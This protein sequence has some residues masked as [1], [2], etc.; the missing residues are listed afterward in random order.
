[1]SGYRTVAGTLAE[2]FAQS[3]A[4]MSRHG[5]VRFADWKAPEAAEI[6]RRIGQEPCTPSECLM[7][8]AAAGLI[9]SCQPPDHLTGDA[10]RI[11]HLLQHLEFKGYRVRRA[12]AADVPSLVELERQ[13]WDEALRAPD[14]AL[15]RRLARHPDGQLVLIVDGTVAA[16]IYSQRIA[17]TDELTGETAVTVEQLHEAAATTVQ[18]LAVNVLPAMQH[19]SLGDALLELMLIRCS[20]DK[21]VKAVAAVTL[22]RS[23]DRTR[24]QP[25]EDYIR[26]RNASGMLS[27][28]ILRFHE[29]HGAKVD[30]L[31]PGYRPHDTRNDGHG[32]LVAYDIRCR[33]RRELH[34]EAAPTGGD[35]QRPSP[36]EIQ[37]GVRSAIAACLGEER[38]A[39]FSP[40]RPLME[41]GLN[42]A[43]LLELGETL[44][45]RHRVPIAPAFFFRHN[46]A[47]KIVAHITQAT[48][49]GQTSAAEPP[50]PGAEER[51]AGRDVAI[52]GMACRLPGGIATPDALWKCL[53]DGKSV[54]SELPAGRWR[55][56]DGIDPSGSH[57]GIARGG[58]LD[59]VADFDAPFFRLSP[60]EAETMDPQQ[61]ILLELCWQAV[62]HAGHA[63]KTLA[64]T[65]TGVFVG[66]SGSDYARLLD[67]SGLP[68][69]AH[70]GTG[71][72]MAVLANR[73]SYFFDLLGPSL[74]LDTACSSSL[75]AVHEAV[76][77]I[78][79]GESAQALVAGVSLILHP[80][81]SVAYYKSGMLSKDGRCKTFDRSA[82]GYVRSEGAVA[83]LLK[84]LER[85]RADGDRIYAVI[86]GTA[87]NHGGQASGLTVPNPDQQSR[88]LEAAWKEAGIDPSHL[89]YIEAH[90]TGTSLGDPI[91]VEGIR[92]AFEHRATTWSGR[93]GLG[94]VKT[95]LGHLE[96]TAGLAGLM[97]AVLCLEH[98]QIPASV[99]FCELNPRIDVAGTGLY[100]VDRLEPWSAPEGGGPRLAGVSSFGSGG[101]NAHV[102]VAE[103]PNAATT[104]PVGDHNEPILFLLSARTQQQLQIYARAYA[105]WLRT[106][107][108]RAVPLSALARLL[109]IGRQAMEARLAL[110]V[111]DREDLVGRLATVTGTSTGDDRASTS[112]EPE[113]ALVRKLIADG[114]LEE[115]AALWQRGAQIDWSLLYGEDAGFERFS[116]PTYPFARRTYWIPNAPA[117]TI[118]KSSGS[119]P[120]EHDISPT[121]LAPVWLPVGNIAEAPLVSAGNGLI[122]GGDSAQREAL[123]SARA[124]THTMANDPGAS[125]NV[126]RDKLAPLGPLDHVIWI[127]PRRDAPPGDLGALAAAQ[128][129]G[130]LAAFRLVKAMIALGHGK[131]PLEWTVV[132]E[133]AQAV[134]ESDSSDPAHAGVHA[135]FNALVKEL[136]R[137]SLRAVDL[138]NCGSLPGH[139]PS[140]HDGEVLARRSGQWL[141]RT[142]S[143]IR[144]VPDA[145]PAY[146]QKGVYVVI[147]GAG[148]I[149]EA[150]SRHVISNYQ[151]Q[152]IWIGRSQLCSALEAKLDA[153]A[154]L[155]P[156][157]IYIAADASSLDALRAAHRKIK[158]LFPAIHGVL[159]A[160]V[161]AFD[162]S[163]AE[164]DE[165][166]FREVLSP[167][168]DASLRMAEVFAA[169]PLDFMIFFSSVVA[170]ERSGG[171]AGYAAGGAFEDA[172][173]VHLDR[174]MSF[175][176][177]V[178]NW[179]HWEVGTGSAIADAARTRL[180]QSGGAPI[181]PDEAMPALDTLIS[182]P[183]AQMALVKTARAGE[184]PFVDM[185]L[186]L[187]FQPDVAPSQ[188]AQVRGQ[189]AR[190]V[191]RLRPASLFN[192]APLEAALTPLLSALLSALGPKAGANA[193]A[194]YERWLDASRRMLSGR[195]ARPSHPT[196]IAQAWQTWSEAKR[197]LLA[198]ADLTAAVD[199]AEACLQAL[200]DVLVGLTRAT[201]VIFPGAS[202]RRV[203]G[204]YRSNAVAEDF[205]RSLTDALVDVVQA[206]LRADPAAQLRILEVGAGT[207][208]TTTTVL[209]RLAP[210]TTN[211][212]EYAYTD[213]SKAFLFH[214]EQ[215]FVAA[216]PFVT[217]RLFDVERPL[218]GQAIAPGTYDAVIATNVLHATR[219]IRRTL[220]NCKAALRK[221]GL[222]LLNEISTPSLFAHVTFGLLEGWWL[223]EDQALRL[224]DAPGLSPEA[225][226]MV[227]EQGGFPAV[228][229]PAPH[230]HVLGQQ[231]IVAESD[232]V[233]WQRS[234]PSA[235]SASTSPQPTLAAAA[236]IQIAGSDG[237]LKVAADA[238]LRKLVARTLR[239]DARELDVH[240]P[241]KTYGIDS[242]LIVQITEALRASF[243]DVS[244]TLLFECQTIDALSQHFLARNR[245]ELEGLTGVKARA[246]KPAST[247]R[248]TILAPSV[249]RSSQSSAESP[250]AIA[251]IGMSGRF[252]GAD[253]LDD[254]WRILKDGQS[255][256]REVPP[257][258]WPLEGFFLADADQAVAQGKSYSKWGGFLDGVTEFDPLFF[259]ISPKEAVAIDPQERLF[260]E[261]AWEALEDAGYTPERISRDFSRALGVFVG[262]TRTG[263]DLFGPE[264]WSRGETVYPHTSFSSAANRLSYFLNAKGP[265]VPVDTMCSSSLTAIHQACQSLRAGECELAIAGG[266][267]VYLHASGYVGLSA[268]R[269]LSPDG[270]CRSFGKGGNG[271]VPGEGVAAILLKPLD[272]AIEDRDRIC[273]VIRATHVNHG[274]RTNGYTVPNPKAQADLVRDALLKAGIDARR[275]SYIEAHGT[276]TEL[277]DPIEVAGLTEAF[278]HFTA[279]TQFCALG[280]AKSTIG[281]LEAAAGI[282]GFIKVVLQMRH[283][284]IAPSLHAAETNPNID[285]ARTPF[286]VQQSLGAWP[287]GEQPRLAGVSSF[288]AGGANAHVVIEEYRDP[289][290]VSSV[291]ADNASYP[292]VLSARSEERLRAYAAR[293][294]DFVRRGLSDGAPL[295]L[296]DVAFTLQV[297]RAQMDQRLG[298]I[299]S[300]LDEL[301]RKLGDYLDGVH[302]DLHVGHAKHHKPVISAID[303]DATFEQMLAAWFARGEHARLLG[304][305]T[306][307]LAIDWERLHQ[308]EPASRMPRRIALPTYPFAKTKYW[309]PLTTGTLSEPARLDVAG[310]SAPIATPEVAAPA[311]V[312]VPTIPSKPTAIRL[313]D[314]AS[315]PTTFAVGSIQPRTLPA[316]ETRTEVQKQA[317]G[318]A[319]L[320]VRDMGDGVLAVDAEG[321]IRPLPTDASCNALIRCLA[322]IDSQAQGRS[323][324][325]S[326]IKVL[327]L[328]GLDRL[329]IEAG[330]SG[331]PLIEK[332]A[333]ALASC[334]V[335]VVAV[336]RGKNSRQVIQLASAC[337]MMILSTECSAQRQNGYRG[338]IVPDS[339]IEA[340]ALA[341]AQSIARGSFV[342]LTT[343]KKH[344]LRRGD[345]QTNRPAPLLATEF[346]RPRS[347]T[348]GTPE[349]VALSSRVV[350][351]DRY[352]NSVALVT[353]ANRAG[354]NTFS[355]E[356][357]SGVLEAFDH[358]NGNPDYKAV[359]VTGYDGYFAC[360]GTREGLLA[361]QSGKARFTDE[362]SYVAPLRCDVPVIAAM[363]GHGIGAGWAMGL[364][365]DGAILA[366]EGVYQSPYMLYGFTP[367]AGS[368]LIFPERLGLDLARE[369]LFTARE[370]QGR[371]LKERGIALPVAPRAEVLPRALAL[372]ESL[373]AA[374]RQELVRRKTERVSAIR[375]CLPE[376]FAAELA[377]H[378]KTFVGNPEVV[379]GLARHFN[380]AASE[381]SSPAATGSAAKAEEP[382]SG[383]LLEALRQSLAHE[384]NMRR[385][386]VDDHAT[387]ID[388]GMD[389]I[390]AVTWIRKINK[391]HGLAIGATKV[392]S[393]PTLAEFHQHVL[394]LKRAQAAPEAASPEQARPEPARQESREATPAPLAKADAKP[395]EP[396]LLECFTIAAQGSP[397]LDIAPPPPV[398]AKE[399]EAK[400]ANVTAT[401]VRHR[402]SATQPIAI[403]GM[404]GQFPKA[405]SV[406]EF[407][408]NLVAGRDCISVVPP[409]RWSVDAYYDPDQNVPGKTVCRYMGVLEDIDVFD[410]L[411]FNI[412][413]SE[414][415]HMD[416]QQRLFLESSWRCIEDAGYDPA[417]L[418]AATCGVFVGCQ[419]N[420]YGRRTADRPSAH[421]LIGESVAMLPARI[422]YFLNLRGPCLTIDTACSASL[423]AIASACDS[424]VLGNADLALAGGVYISDGPDIHLKMSSAG[425][426]SPNGRC[427]TFDQR[428]NGFVLGEG[429]GVLLLK[430]LDDALR[431]GDP[432][433]AV[434]RGWGVNQDGKTNGITA[435][436]QESQASLEAGVY[437]R[438]GIDPEHIGLVEAHGTGTKLGDPIEVEA[439]CQSFRR[440]TD[441]T[442]FCAL[443]S[444]KSNIGHLA[445]A[446]GVTGVI[447]AALALE[448]RQ[449]PQT[450]NYERLNEHIALA[451][452]PFY[453][454]TATQAW[455]AEPGRQRLA[456]V[457]SFGFSGTNAHMVLEEFVQSEARPNENPAPVLVP[458]SAKSNAQ[459]ARY[460][461]T[462]AAHLAG[463][464]DRELADIA[465]TFQIGRTAMSHRLAVV[466]STVDELR[467]R[468]RAYASNGATGPQSFAGEVSK[469]PARAADLSGEDLPDLAKRWV[470]GET[471]DWDALYRSRKP[472]RLHGLPTY[473]FAREHYWIATD[474]EMSASTELP[475]LDAAVWPSRELPVEIDWQDR[476]RDWLGKRSLVVHAGEDERRS[477][478]H[479]LSRLQRSCGLESIGSV[480]YGRVGDAPLAKA[481]P[482]CLVLLGLSKAEITRHLAEARS[483]QTI[484]ASLSADPAE[485]ESIGARIAAS[486]A[487]DE[488]KV[489]LVSH[490]GAA[491]QHGVMQHLFREWLA[492]AG[493]S[494][495]AARRE[496]Y[497]TGTARQER[498]ARVASSPD[499]IAILAKEWHATAPEL[500][501]RPADRK[502]ALVLVNSETAEIARDLFEPADF[503]R[504]ILVGTD[505]AG[506]AVDFG[507]AHAARAAADALIARYPGITH[508]IDFASLHEAPADGDADP[509]GKVAFY[510]ALIGTSEDLA[511][512]YVTKGL[513]AFRSETMSLAGAKF[514]GL[515]RM[516]S[517]DYRHIEARHL[518]IDQAAFGSPAKLRRI[519]LDEL[520]T[521]LHETEICYRDGHR[522]VP[523]LSIAEADDQAESFEIAPDATYVVS[524]GTNGIGLEI[525]RHLADKGCTK[526][527]LMGIT[528]LPP[529]DTWSQAL[530]RDDVSPYIRAKLAALI[531]LDNV[532]EHLEIYTGPL[533]DLPALRRY[534]MKVRATLGPIRGV[535]HSAAVYSDATT[536]AFADKK[537][538][539]MQKVWEPKV[540]GLESLEAVFRADTL[541]FFVAFSSMT[542]LVPHLARGAG[543][544]AMANVFV[545]LFTAYHNRQHG[546]HPYK[547]IVW[548]DWNETG[549]ITRIG[550]DKAASIRETFE[551]LGLRTFSNAEGRRLFDAAMA[552][553][554]S[555]T[556]IGYLDRGRFAKVAPSLLFAT[557]EQSRRTAAPPSAP[558]LKVVAG[559][560]LLDHLDRWEA[561]KRA[562][563][564]ISVQSVTE[565]IGLD[566]IKSL[567]PSL[568]RRIHALLFGAVA[569][570]APSTA[571]RDYTHAITTTVMGVLKLKTVSPEQPLQNYGLDSISATVLATRL[572][573]MLEIEIRPQWLIEFPTIEALSR[574]LMAEADKPR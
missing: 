245:E 350:T 417:Q 331:A 251:V 204:I 416:P 193:P 20:L 209:P 359:V 67:Q 10:D 221:G 189:T 105:D 39:A 29:L 296:A 14:A 65:R 395:A 532:V 143:P 100:V 337:D 125:I 271:F 382:A 190:D 129:A 201:D 425:M 563:A 203:E 241:L 292:I 258:R 412:S 401:A 53:K 239:M 106:D 332:A 345:N 512:L 347:T 145:P 465:H 38:K 307:G 255:V 73:I 435:P 344:L 353:L 355:P 518:D 415:E 68:T 339:E 377:M 549:G 371:E 289:E 348:L 375:E 19:R 427:F 163:V 214:A 93:C 49:P 97:K 380:D 446:A 374:S 262:I 475:A 264:L 196:G 96:A 324:S 480:A 278:R 2:L 227:L 547:A 231:V 247:V 182:A 571:P 509:S 391:Q 564:T 188:I 235:S 107:G 440:F 136:P 496:V 330:S 500:M 90:G 397:P 329:F 460:A 499:G 198:S 254:Y 402:Q 356:F 142:F 42:S 48:R 473:P 183:V 526:L 361:I 32:V 89:G 34:L 81:A 215:E 200:P 553:T 504:I 538:G 123:C 379:A 433:R 58:F 46:T 27:D 41:M 525:A 491:D 562:G 118:A 104:A 4:E 320:A 159:H 63:P 285:F 570:A 403:I 156:R 228:V 146:R 511:I 481:Q 131:R 458:L 463:C 92:L 373:A 127:S 192:N 138:D 47:E 75:V 381:S 311:P 36:H 383:E 165:Q 110:V 169:E 432:V 328:S 213:I 119:D 537:L 295:S 428:A 40:D 535:I 370:Y 187:S 431:D 362:Q 334:T 11:D 363:Q 217:P 91:E 95:N 568:I 116:A 492:F 176:V 485:A 469:K 543:D 60:A 467:T 293:L 376:V 164:T 57:R 540:D 508:V 574:H 346:A 112:P 510:Q 180:R 476:L 259:N 386:D 542:G 357:V 212:A 207:G 275:V 260:L 461:E 398:S 524:G 281:H 158:E 28:P 141:R 298:L 287:G 154:H 103:C 478:A 175:P 54:I 161:G 99:N 343:L 282:A 78:A 545:E 87:S 421:G 229:F 135:F 457:S 23:F 378:D 472:R 534:F 15:R 178:I 569:E 64:G 206:R 160:A 503:D 86:K 31:V 162:R 114:D 418:S 238:H 9:P 297:G 321:I 248:E 468:L 167:K 498:V 312:G 462:L 406:D 83:L 126:L 554:A 519:I 539:R 354:K 149:G 364:F 489:L 506:M 166:R 234:E 420:D 484:V 340:Y 274:G 567:D 33:R 548:S 555:H 56:P 45:Q 37:E 449:L 304:L 396:I 284:A 387:F 181:Q 474:K 113:L 51:K 389:S 279:D 464:R 290:P 66:A 133:R 550:P 533:T 132:T 224:P 194:F 455:P 236:E 195:A 150:W 487:A 342:A 139:L 270:V 220:A 52:V 303:G 191:E 115:L 305:W 300:S 306:A 77:S 168:I 218:A 392:Y 522:F 451:E 333:S 486:V 351:L 407:W 208:G 80:A 280:S 385:E 232:G 222:L 441:K 531:E 437:E 390:S 172:L 94:S 109:Q 62:E 211:I 8:A 155:G 24:G 124:G 202:M 171:F 148:G 430:R 186:S 59:G 546:R 448:H 556:I 552:S 560:S 335:P 273:A 523:V 6:G 44:A 268:A 219:D 520:A 517:A 144:G 521:E 400:P 267:N 85:A 450:I 5:I 516:L 301:Q 438:F 310:A 120:K 242:I 358:I 170:L 367:G 426:L 338:P 442:A 177:K 436:S 558:A 495:T 513:Q 443:S 237:A 286:V 445:T 477:F 452:S 494:P 573:K 456:A 134:F 368:T 352:A 319:R 326:P 283:G 256:V 309:L 82:D 12:E 121:L 22:C 527:V 16:V 249:K 316:L 394:K 269:M 291:A 26:E 147:G 466:A 25:L 479:F 122:V 551:Q 336:I 471:V 529:K 459:L 313:A 74:T 557:R 507:D 384:L 210:F 276:G 323:R 233:V 55:W 424:L 294:R 130:L 308:V 365:C 102:V 388:C 514:A 140:G 50:Q 505:E 447:K 536:P 61:R 72:S 153:L 565:V 174:S 216:Y 349:R 152:V 369:V 404:A 429:V 197:G 490:P 414:A 502:T 240:E 561:E 409:E 137:W 272:R 528:P 366:E 318:E 257:D 411:F 302:D 35:R 399:P 453:V 266:V 179:G 246:A 497:Y 30:R 360:G 419:A 265:S 530:A 244:S 250:A 76:R 13:C 185:S 17:S 84:P 405:A 341:T 444:A 410:P 111:R 327:L 299:A 439:L 69:E 173:A 253:T 98:R 223:C 18:L 71:S 3:A 422:A 21:S 70:Y 151:A 108:G 393:H 482:E 263:F 483:A 157:P 1:M 372:A 544:Y 315:I 101:S 277:G 559:P 322:W 117:G 243:P 572:E 288:G 199:L 454:C 541:D 314:P 225:W 317:D 43:D 413:P 470:A 252:P 423:V 488:R 566:E 515:V 226:R 205:N 88:L 128:E 493:D 325:D 261:T 79:A 184:L 7:A 501:R 434:I 230:A 408:Q